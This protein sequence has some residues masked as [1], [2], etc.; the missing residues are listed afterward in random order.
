MIFAALRQD[1][2]LSG[3]FSPIDKG[4]PV[5]GGLCPATL[6]ATAL[7]VLLD[8]VGTKVNVELY[9]WRITHRLEAVDLASLDD[10]DVSRAAL[11]GFA[12]YYPHSPA[13]TDELDLVIG[14]P[15]RTRPR[16]GFPMEQEHRNT[17]VAL[18]SSDKLMRTTNKGQVLLTHV[19]HLGSPSCQDLMTS[20]TVW[21]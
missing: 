16:S 18:L 17:S 6:Q 10:K 4:C 19:K 1:H 3:N 7:K 13:F 5:C 2:W 15:V 20:A 9:Q 21:L 14:M 8:E 11:E 12:A